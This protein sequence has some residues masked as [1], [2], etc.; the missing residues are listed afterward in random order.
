MT[1]TIVRSTVYL[2]TKMSSLLTKMSRLLTK[3]VKS[4]SKRKFSS[5]FEVL[6][7]STL[8]SRLSTMLNELS[9]V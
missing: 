6:N 1:L 4:H 3:I 7:C 8:N 5:L 9:R 2:R